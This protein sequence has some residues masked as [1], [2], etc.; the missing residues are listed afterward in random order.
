MIVNSEEVREFFKK[1]AYGKTVI[2]TNGNENYITT[3]IKNLLASYRIRSSYSAVIGVFCSDGKAY[4]AATQLGMTACW[5]KIPGLGIEDAY[6][7]CNAGSELY[8]RLCFVKILLIKYALELGY[9]VLYIDPDM[10][11]NKNCIQELLDVKDE[12]TFAKYYIHGPPIPFIN[13]NIM[14][15]YPT[16]FTLDVFN[17][18]VTKDLPVYLGRLPDVSDETFLTDRLLCLGKE[19][20]K[21]LEMRHYPSGADS[22]NSSPDEIKMFHANCIIGLQNKIDYMRQNGVWFL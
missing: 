16:P 2:F 20:A 19:K 14:R 8:L 21:S 1:I 3:L 10:S 18:V 22:K 17:F 12:L 9:D 13:S 15:V 11:F 4:E 7:S 6:K 5:A